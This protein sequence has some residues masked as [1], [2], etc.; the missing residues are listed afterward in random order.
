MHVNRRGWIAAGIYLSGGWTV[1]CCGGPLQKR[2]CSLY[3]VLLVCHH[4]SSLNRA[5]TSQIVPFLFWSTYIS[6]ILYST[7]TSYPPPSSIFTTKASQGTHLRVIATPPS[8]TTLTTSP[9]Q[10]AFGGRTDPLAKPYAPPQNLHLPLLTV[11]TQTC[12]LPPSSLFIQHGRRD[13]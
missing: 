11:L 3:I 9:H 6:F 1:K 7:F 2:G 5:A 8:I 4:R 12:I 13:R 10:S